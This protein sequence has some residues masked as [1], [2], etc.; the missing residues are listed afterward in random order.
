MTGTTEK[1]VELRIFIF[2]TV[3]LFPALSVAA[4]GS[5]GFIVWI[6]QLIFGPPVV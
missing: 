4:M 1:Y 5:Y 3:F 2:I 6:S